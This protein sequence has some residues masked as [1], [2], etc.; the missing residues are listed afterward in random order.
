MVYDV[1]HWVIE[2]RG[3]GERRVEGEIVEGRVG[4]C[5]QRGK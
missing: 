2:E 4:V 3:M 5:S 1:I